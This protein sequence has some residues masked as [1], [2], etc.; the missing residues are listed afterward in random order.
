MSRLLPCTVLFTICLQ[1]M[2]YKTPIVL[3]TGSG[4]MKAGFSDEEH[5]N[6]IFPTIIG[7]PKYEE[8]MNGYL[9]RDVYI[10]HEAQ[11]MRGVLALMHP[12][13]NGIIR[14][15]DEMEKI[16]HHTFQQLCVEPEDHPVL[17]TE[18]AM[19]PL[20]N[21][22]RMVEIMFECFNVPFTYVAMQAVLVL[23]AAGR[24][25]GVVFDSG[26]GVS[27]SVP[28]FE[29]YCLPHAV[30][31]FPLAGVDV[32]MQLTKLLQEQGVSMRSTAE[33]EIVREMKEKCC[34]VALNYEAE[35]SRGGLSCGETHYTMP[36]GQI[37]TLS[38]FQQA[39]E[40]LF[41][42]ELIG[43]DHY[44]IHESIFKSILSSDID[45]RRCLL[46]NIVL[47][48]GNTLLPGLPERLQAEIKSLVPDR[49]FSVWSGGAVL[50][51]LP[52]FSSCF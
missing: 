16:W 19:N 18:A 15:W 45:L 3:D 24:T 27:H 7:M 9:E 1:M 22:E 25:T 38:A 36:D 40:I 41:K 46:G 21:R 32:T 37:V 20:E 48:G 23:Y 5:P 34:C 30:H 26:D 4:L 49:D 43:Q 2:D 17:L 47:S 33:L 8:I 6:V 42:P 11:H 52:T 35:L 50:A 10:G 28:V 51:N 29:G 39:P 14:N 12:I 13:K 44:G 31:R